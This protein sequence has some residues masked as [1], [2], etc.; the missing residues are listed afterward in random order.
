MNYYNYGTSG[1]R[2][3]ESIM[4]NI[5]EKIGIGIGTL[6]LSMIISEH[7]TAIEHNTKT[8]KFIGI[9]ITAS[10]NQYDD[11]G[12]KII[13]KNGYMI[14]SDQELL[15]EQIVNSDQ[16]DIS[17]TSL[18]NYQPYV[19]I[20]HDTR[21]S[22]EEIKT[23]IIHGIQKIIPDVKIIDLNMMTTPELHITISESKYSSDDNYYQNKIK[24]LIKKYNLAD[25]LNNYILDCA[26]G[27]GAT[28]MNKIMSI[29]LI[30]TNTSDH[31]QLNNNAGSDY[32]MNNRDKFH[33][34]VIKNSKYMSQLHGA[35]DGDADRLIFYK[36]TD[37]NFYIMNGDY[38]SL[39]VLKYTCKII[40]G[41]KNKISIGVIHTGYSNGGFMEHVDRISESLKDMNI[42]I[43][44]QCV[45]T[46]VKNLISAAIKYDIGI[47]FESN[48][49]GSVYVNESVNH[50][51][52]LVPLRELF[53]QVIGDGIMNFFG[54]IYILDQLNMNT[55]EFCNLFTPRISREIKVH[56]NNKNIYVTSENQTELLEPIEIKDKI[57]K[58]I[59]N[60]QGLRAFVR[61]SGTEDILRL[62]VENNNSGDLDLDLIV[63]DFFD[64][65]Y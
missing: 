45:K 10:H 57:D 2:F 21:R 51:H 49:H 46:G 47:Y 37:D 40:S 58:I 60:N 33:K 36:F 61:P 38:I 23:K 64:I 24:H 59:M 44:R 34:Y 8:N 12:V 15:L 14:S 7:K 42:T 13:D 29:N 50:I 19:Y 39:L 20:A 41:L 32:V 1:F 17:I 43:T 18:V 11:N 65:L 22:C 54:V 48:G 28:T 55:M 4:I 52:E 31:S 9:M 56:V 16:S 26:N 35:L 6:L 53:N 3:D 63:K 25:K 62:Y 30:N 5:A 27:V